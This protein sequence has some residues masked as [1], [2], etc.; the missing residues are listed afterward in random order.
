M[1]EFV[2]KS[3]KIHGDKYD[4]SFVNYVNA[5][6]QIKIIC[7]IHGVFLQTPEKHLLKR[8]CNLCG[9]IVRND[10]LRKTLDE[11]VNNARKIHGNLYDYSKVDYIITHKK[12]EIICSKHDFS[13]FV[14]PNNHLSLKRG[15]PKCSCTIS[16]PE[17]E[18]LDY[19]KILNENRQIRLLNKRVDG[20]DCETNTVYEFLGDYYHGNPEKY[21]SV[22]YNPTCHKTFGQLYEN[23]FNRLNKLKE[24][25]YN[26][27]YIW[28]NNW[29]RFK[30]GIDVTP[31]IIEI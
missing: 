8:G 24:N 26:I 14:T 22:D 4:Y 1:E 3:S 30:S 31:N 7:K 17:I 9:M 6:T 16:K 12:I 15:C 13:F 28:E 11:F 23:T 29:K 27:K 20:F 19:V 18:F 10:G 25:G 21:K 5:K 2:E